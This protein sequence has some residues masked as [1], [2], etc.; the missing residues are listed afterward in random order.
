LGLYWLALLSLSIGVVETVI[1]IVR[2]DLVPI[3]LVVVLIGLVEIATVPID[4]VAT[5][6]EIVRTDLVPIGLVEIDFVRTSLVVT[7]TVLIGVV[8][9]FVELQSILLLT[10][11]TA[12]Y[13]LLV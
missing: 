13:T 11:L 10:G 7:G 2:T 5:V 3:A 6:I 8:V 9:V 1:E 4:F 12:S